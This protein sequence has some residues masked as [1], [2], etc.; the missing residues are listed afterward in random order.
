ML[1]Y[2]AKRVL[3]MIPTLFGMSLIAFMIIQLPPGD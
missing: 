2:V 1:A 3:Y